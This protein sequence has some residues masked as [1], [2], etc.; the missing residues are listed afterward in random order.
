MIF[1]AK[2][3]LA[4]TTLK[5]GIVIPISAI[6]TIKKAKNNINIIL[7]PSI[8]LM[9]TLYFTTKYPKHHIHKSETQKFPIKLFKGNL[10]KNK[11]TIQTIS[12]EVLSAKSMIFLITI[13]NALS[14]K[15]F[16]KNQSRHKKGYSAPTP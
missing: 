11:N 3:H 10:C 6:R 7:F 2:L 14:I 16:L 15:R 8:L 1:M 5:T 12:I 4:K 13:A 9:L